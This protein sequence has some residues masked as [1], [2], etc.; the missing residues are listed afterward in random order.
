LVIPQGLWA[1]G[2]DLFGL[3]AVALMARGLA[4]CLRGDWQSMDASLMS[5]SYQ[6]EADDTLQAL[7]AEPGASRTP[8]GVAR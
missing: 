5:R 6:E 3:A 4:Q 1:L 8:E 7:G 2:F